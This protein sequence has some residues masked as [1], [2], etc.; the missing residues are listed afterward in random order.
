MLEKH[1]KELEGGEGGGGAVRALGSSQCNSRTLKSLSLS[2]ADSD[3][4]GSSSNWLRQIASFDVFVGT[5]LVKFLRY[6]FIIII[7]KA[8]ENYSYTYICT[9][10]DAQLSPL[11]DL[12]GSK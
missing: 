11:N 12:A 10:Q 5:S 8:H 6:I 1:R 4:G 2:V 9:S 3:I 7:H